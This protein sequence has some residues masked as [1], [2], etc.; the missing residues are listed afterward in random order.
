[1]AKLCDKCG[2]DLVDTREGFG[3][4]SVITFAIL[5]LIS[6]VGTITL[7]LLLPVW[8]LVLIGSLTVPFVLRKHLTVCS[9][10]GE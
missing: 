3:S 5:F 10:C 2:G 9:N 1:M 7:P 4:S 6:L 8:I